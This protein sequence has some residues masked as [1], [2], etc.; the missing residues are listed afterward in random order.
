MNTTISRDA[1][2]AA[3]AVLAVKSDPTVYDL[4]RISDDN[5]IPI[6][7][8]VKVVLDLMPA[9]TAGVVGL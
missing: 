7:D 5:D 6:M 4:A 8:L 9:D 1:A 3:A 2:V